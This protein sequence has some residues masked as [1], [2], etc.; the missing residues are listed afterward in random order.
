MCARL[1]MYVH[2]RVCVS[3]TCMCDT[4]HVQAF[5]WASLCGGA[6]RVRSRF[7]TLNHPL[8]SEEGA[9]PGTVTCP[10]FLLLDPPVSTRN[11]PQGNK[12]TGAPWV[13]S[14]PKLSWEG[15]GPWHCEVKGTRGGCKLTQRE[16]SRLWARLQVQLLA[17][18][19]SIKNADVVLAY[20]FSVQASLGSGADRFKSP[21][22]QPRRCRLWFRAVL[23]PV[24]RR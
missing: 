2:A 17:D 3:P 24:A 12:L 16:G 5:V 7:Q 19:F 9:A 14:F 21:R 13:E 20:C 18:L 22:H 8:S 6:A 23:Q 11:W 1:C 10:C 15:V 4:N